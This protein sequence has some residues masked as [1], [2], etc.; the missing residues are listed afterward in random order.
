[1][2]RISKFVDKLINLILGVSLIAIVILVF[3]NVVLRYIFDSGLIWGP[4]LSRYIF[5]WMT[6]VG[7]IAA[8]K[9]NEHLAVNMVIKRL[10]ERIKKIVIILG[11]LIM[12]GVLYIVITGSWKMTVINK[13]SSSPATG[14]PLSVIYVS[15]I[16]LGVSM[17]IIILINTYKL[18][19]N[20]A[21][22]E[23]LVPPER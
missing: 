3:C 15:G 11:N 14:L 2:N 17:V 19:F 13:A 21:S 6:F 4:E 1:M 9:H 5:I 20:K 23:E 12:L 16:V 10:P 22:G 8:L 7:A 18:L